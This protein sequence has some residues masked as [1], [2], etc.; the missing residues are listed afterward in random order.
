[1]FCVLDKPKNKIFIV[2]LSYEDQ[3]NGFVH[4]LHISEVFLEFFQG[5]E[6]GRT[7]ASTTTRLGLSQV[8]VKVK[9]RG[10]VFVA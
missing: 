7:Q 1:M 6:L 2:R 10:T 9:H 4:Q 3:A 5:L 8:L